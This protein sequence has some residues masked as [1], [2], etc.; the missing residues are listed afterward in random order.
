MLPAITDLEWLQ[1]HTEPI[2]VYEYCASS[3][4]AEGEWKS[5]STESGW[6]YISNRAG[7]KAA[8][9]V[10]KDFYQYRKVAAFGDNEND[11]DLLLASDCSYIRK[12][13]AEQTHNT[14]QDCASVPMIV[15][16]IWKET[17]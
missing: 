6:Q 11:K 2:A 4:P 12:E 14:F 15:N 17:K 13:D 3:H 16:K 7:K 8:V 10:L 5:F 9:Q 1:T